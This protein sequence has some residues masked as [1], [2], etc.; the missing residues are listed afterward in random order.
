[1]PLKTGSPPWIRAV[2]G[3]TFVF[4]VARMVVVSAWLSMSPRINFEVLRLAAITFIVGSLVSL[5]L[6]IGT[7]K[8]QPSG[9]VTVTFLVL[10]AWPPL[11]RL[12]E[13]ATPSP[14]IVPGFLA[15]VTLACVLTFRLYHPAFRFLLLAIIVVNGLSIAIVSPWD[16]FGDAELFAFPDVAR[17]DSASDTD[18]VVVVL[19]GYGRSDLM[20]Q[21][22]GHDNAALRGQLEEAGFSIMDEAVA[23]YHGSF[24]SIGSFLA[25]DYMAT[26]DSAL[27]RAERLAIQ[28]VIG[29]N[30]PFIR[31][32]QASGREYTHVSSPWIENRC[33]QN[34]DHCI[35]G[36]IYD[37]VALTWLQGDSFYGPVPYVSMHPFPASADNALRELANMDFSSDDPAAIFIHVTSPHIP[38]MLSPDCSRA[39]HRPEGTIEDQF[40]CVDQLVIEALSDIPRDAIVVIFGDH[41][42]DFPGMKLMTPDA[43]T[44]QQVLNRLA[45]FV[46]VRLPQDCVYPPMDTSLINVSRYVSACALGEEPQPL[47]NRSF[48]TPVGYP[49]TETPIREVFVP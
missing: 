43:W 41:G 20:K 17:T 40:A 39:S 9:L 12:V 3:P 27:S 30:N 15:V 21:V 33:A 22:Y 26:P 5:L 10:L 49:L 16:P 24:L 11:F 7:G 6:A 2:V 13:L 37:T 35:R 36:P 1:M 42:P 31:N 25:Q 34:V 45:A 32:L 47:P 46:A 18:V 4:V 44:D 28:N 38:Y 14:L 48:I 19:D 23:N 8:P 29:G